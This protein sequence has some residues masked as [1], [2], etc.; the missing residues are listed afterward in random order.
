MHR[1][2]RNRRGCIIF[3]IFKRSDSRS[4]G[5]KR[6]LT[7]NSH[8][9]SFKVIHFA[10]SYRPYLWSFRRRSHLNRQNL[11]SS[12]TRNVVWRPGP[13]ETPRIFAWAL[14]FQKLESLAYI[15]VADS[16]GLASFKFVQWAA[17]GASILQHSVGRKRILT[18][19]NHSRSFKVIHFP[20]SYQ[21][22]RGSMSPYN[23]ADLI[24]EGSEEVA[25]QIAKNCRRRHPH[26]HLMPPPRE[27]PANI[28]IHVIFPET[29]II[30][31][32]FC[33]W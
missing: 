32:H 12:T 11:P 2:P 5:R 25:T 3:L 23:T 8:S 6:I 21:P 28:P 18:S 17:E 30:G 22:T 13:G 1:T 4:A 20:I 16:M 26:S 31:L 33:C 15:F 24:S 9:R 14:Y 7:W 19:N 27:T 10:I 29:R